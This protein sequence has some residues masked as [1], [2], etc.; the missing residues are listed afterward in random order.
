MIGGKYAG[1]FVVGYICFDKANS[2]PIKLFDLFT[3]IYRVPVSC[4]FFFLL[5]QAQYGAGCGIETVSF[6]FKAQYQMHL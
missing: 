6:Q 2:S 1:A 4:V 5:V 3:N